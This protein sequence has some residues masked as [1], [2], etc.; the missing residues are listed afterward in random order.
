MDIKSR[1][2]ITAELAAGR[3]TAARGLIDA[4][5]SANPDSFLG[6]AYRATVRMEL[7]ETGA[8]ITELQQVA[9][10]AEAAGDAG[11]AAFAELWL[12]YL[13]NRLRDRERAVVHFE[14]SAV[15]APASDDLCA[16]LCQTYVEMGREAKAR[17][18]GMKSLELRAVEGKCKPSEEVPQQRPRAFDPAAAPRNV[19]AFSLFGA[20]PFYREAAITVARSAGGIFPEFTCRFYCGVE[21]PGPVR[22]AL[23]AAG[24]Q[25]RVVKA[26]DPN[27]QHPF[28]GLMWRFL[29]FD[30]SDVDVVLVRDVDSPFTLRER[31]AVDLWLARDE[32]FFSI[33]DDL[34]HTE[35]LMAGMWGGF[36]GLLGPLGPAAL[37]GLPSD[38]SR[39][40]DQRFLR[41]FVWPRIR[42]A[43][44][45]IDSVYKLGKT[46]EF[47][48]RFP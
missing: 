33:R 42:S 34:N 7:G 17:H 40:I 32:P 30:D 16:A 12:G 19:I 3:F 28:A 44:L 6:L 1:T 37:R 11:A 9:Q 14:R 43:T 38:R 29:A 45:A 26:N 2:A 10:R 4:H 39:F 20:D 22:K 46:A 15:L 41:Q 21:I 48:T 13:H 23:A 31:A 27:S 24:A 47:P 18:W 36:T 35:P 8:A 25:V 5:L